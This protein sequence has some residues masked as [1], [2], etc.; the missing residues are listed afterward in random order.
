MDSRSP[1]DIKNCDDIATSSAGYLCIK[2]GNLYCYHEEASHWSCTSI[3]SAN[4]L[5]SITTG[6]LILY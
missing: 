2:Q 3:N 6:I 1:I 4:S 5:L